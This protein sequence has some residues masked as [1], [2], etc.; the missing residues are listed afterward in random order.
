MP[1]T[2]R[3]Q[4]AK[5]RQAVLNQWRAHVDYA[6]ALTPEQ[7]AE[8]SK[9]TGWD[10]RT[11]VGH[12]AFTVHT[13][14][15]RAAEPVAGVEAEVFDW[16][17]ASPTAASM[18]DAGTRELV[19]QGVVLAD[20]V[21]AAEKVM[22]RYGD[23]EPIAM[24]FGGMR[25]DDFLVSRIVEAVVHGDDL[26]RSTGREFPHDREALAITVRQLADA[27]AAKVPGNSVELRVPPFAA[28]QCVPGPRHTRGTPP[29]VVE[30]APKT[31]LRLAAGRVTWDEALAEA[32]ISASGSRAD[33]QEFLPLMG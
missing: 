29:N 8:P 13:V 10:V 6:A 32:K 22:A 23:E 26:E 16:M 25:F 19:G 15:V 21:A 30:I 28:V 1:K 24:R 4:P 27:M 17:T 12:V 33:L 20:E 31:W 2:R 5:V 9:L 7:L 3:P 11:L 18:V 14:Q